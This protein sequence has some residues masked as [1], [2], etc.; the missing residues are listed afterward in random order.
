MTGLHR[1]EAALRGR[2]QAHGLGVRLEPRLAQPLAQRA[3]RLV[4]AAGG[5]RLHR[6]EL[7]CEAAC[8]APGITKRG[9][10]NACRTSCARM[11][12]LAPTRS[13]FT[14]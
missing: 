7:A 14:R 11:K 9:V 3:E 1:A 10:K 12:R 8:E 13:C 2:L 6:R 4:V 5:R